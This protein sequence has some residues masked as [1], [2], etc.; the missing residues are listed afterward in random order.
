MSEDVDEITPLKRKPGRPRKVPLPTEESE[1][2]PSDPDDPRIG[3]S[4]DTAWSGIGYDDGT[5]YRCE[6]GV[7]VERVH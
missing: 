1:T 2:V 7:I 4:C 6:N 5:S 3:Q